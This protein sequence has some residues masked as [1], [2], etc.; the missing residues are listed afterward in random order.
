[1]KEPQ[2][3]PNR[4]SSKDYKEE[5]TRVS[6]DSDEIHNKKYQEELTVILADQN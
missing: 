1:V 4:H 3:L 5:A 6:F 2:G